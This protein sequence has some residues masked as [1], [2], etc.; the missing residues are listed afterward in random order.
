MIK[1]KSV[2]PLDK[3]ETATLKD[4]KKALDACESELEAILQSPL[5]SAYKAITK[6]INEWSEQLESKP[7]NIFDDEQDGAFG[8]SHKF[9]IEL[10]LYVDSREKLLKQMSPEEKELAG[11]AVTRN[12]IDPRRKD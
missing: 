11:D 4:Y 2:L 1:S 5:L 7:L 9:F 12:V 8:R 10:S 6:K 3:R